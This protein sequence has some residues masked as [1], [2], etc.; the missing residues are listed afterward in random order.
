MDGFEREHIRYLKRLAENLQD[1]KLYDCLDLLQ[2]TILSKEA[3]E[4]EVER[5]RGELNATKN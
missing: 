5:L 3:Y 4:A 1:R 2:N